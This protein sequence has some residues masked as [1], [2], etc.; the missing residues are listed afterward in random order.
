VLS[1]FS[2]FLGVGAFDPDAP[3]A[4]E[5][6]ARPDGSEAVFARPLPPDVTA[7]LLFATADLIAA[8]EGHEVPG[9]ATATVDTT[10]AGMPESA[11]AAAAIREVLAGRSLGGSTFLAAIIDPALPAWLP[12]PA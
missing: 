3:L 10:H 12:P 5:V 9:A 1:W 6:L 11:P 4:R 7:V 2:R 8:P